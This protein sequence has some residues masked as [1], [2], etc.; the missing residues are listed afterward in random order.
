MRLFPSV[1]STLRLVC[2]PGS[3][4]AVCGLLAFGV[5][6]G[7]Q[8]SAQ[9]SGTVKTIAGAFAGYVDGDN[10]FSEFNQPF[11]A[12]FDKAGNVYIADLGNNAVRKLNPATTVVTTVIPRPNTVNPL[13]QPVAIVLD[14]ADNIYVA[15]QGNGVV[16]Q[17]DING[18]LRTAI[19]SGLAEPTALGL[20]NRTNLYIA[21]LGGLVKRVDVKGVSTN[22]FTVPSGL[23]PPQIR[24]LTV[25]DNGRIVVSDA[26]NHVLWIYDPQ[27]LTQKLTTLAG[28]KGAGFTEGSA[29]FAQFN[30]PHHV[31]KG[32][33]NSVYVADRLNHR[34]RMVGCDGNVSTAYGISSNDWFVVSQPGVFP[35]WDDGPVATAE[36]REPV[37]L[38]VSS[39]GVIYA[40]E[41]YYHVIRQ[42]TGVASP[43]SCG[44]GGGGGST[45]AIDGPLLSPNSGYFPLGVLV[46][47][48]RPQDNPFTPDARI[49][50]TINGTDPTTNSIFA[51]IV[52]GHASIFFRETRL[53]LTALRVKVFEGTNSSATVSGQPASFD[54]PFVG[55]IGFPGT[56]NGSTIYAG[57]GATIAVPVIANLR[58]NQ[59]L[60][61]L[62]FLL[63]V[64]PNGA[65][66]PIEPPQEIRLVPMS[67]ND[68]LPVVAASPGLP[69]IL[70]STD[71]VT[72]RLAIAYIGTNQVFSVT[73][74]GAVSMVAIP[75]PIKASPGDTYSLR[76]SKISG[77]SD[78]VQANLSLLAMADRQIVVTN[79]SYAVGDTS[80]GYWYNAGDFGDGRLNNSD[81][82]NAF[83]ASFGFRL[84]YSFSDA[85]DAMDAFPVDSPPNAGGDGLIRFL[86]WQILL[87]R[88]LGLDD[89]NF[90][91]RWAADGIRESTGAAPALSLVRAG[92]VRKDP[93]IVWRRDAVITAG[94]VEKAARG[95]RVSAPVHARVKN[96][97]SLSGLQFLARVQPVAGA[98]AVSSVNFIP[99]LGIRTPA[100]SG[101]TV[102]GAALAGGFYCAWN[103][104]EL[105]G[106]STG[107][108]DLLGYISFSVPA[109]A[110]PGSRYDVS[111]GNADGAG[112]DQN[113]LDIESIHGSIWVESSAAEPAP[114]FSDEWK[115]TFFGSGSE[116]DPN[117]DADGDGFSNWVEYLAGSNPNQP[118]WRFRIDS[119][120]FT[121]RWFGEV[122]KVYAVKRSVSIS[123]WQSV[124]SPI[125]GAGQW[126]E[127]VDNDGLQ[128]RQFYRL[129]SH[130]AP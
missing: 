27:A 89:H 109:S 98:P 11:A 66:R 2:S 83:Y 115:T 61:S 78:G 68:F 130:L 79:I 107:E 104:G 41:V 73:T 20:D 71:G 124:G 112:S 15:N 52:N 28:G 39:E 81:V 53:D 85:F 128:N 55:E 43:A 57:I 91:R 102:R 119:G 116:P 56:L 70:T 6:A 62:Q 111:F 122:G 13:T 82:N 58:A 37:G 31:A 32:P 47:V 3:F 59:A 72:N 110:S 106:S 63:E 5:L 16:F 90:S 84:P 108:S 34:V 86:D 10:R 18:N 100:V 12:A 93:E 50:Y 29:A 129:E 126:V 99:A 103:L 45:N 40:T 117:G 24:G 30:Q 96:G 46:D 75:I 9:A 74:F 1:L 88:S 60:R 80:I 65:A 8:A 123:D 125:P 95:S 101:D 97:R 48:T 113:S 42:V 87:R 35:G 21:L 121:F 127:F 4:G 36:A 17:Y 19:A 118:N 77:T 26:A 44:S 120:K 92:G 114:V 67:D 69:T 25:L 14:R 7:R 51:P 54:Q 22:L 76:V 49:Y 38:A 94:V 33:N 105:R 23:V 64:F